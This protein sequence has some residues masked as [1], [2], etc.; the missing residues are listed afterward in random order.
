MFYS[1]KIKHFVIKRPC[2]DLHIDETNFRAESAVRKAFMTSI[3]N[4]VS[5]TSTFVLAGGRG[6]R[7]WPLTRHRSKP[8][9]PFGD[10]CIIDFTLSNC[11]GSNLFR[12]HVLTQY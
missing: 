2:N 8:A 12:P 10:R 7:L 11:L 4:I 1:P 5:Q 9:L 3:Q 6:S